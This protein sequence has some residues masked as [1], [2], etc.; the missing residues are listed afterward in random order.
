M[1]NSIKA[2]ES[3]E[4]QYESHTQ[5]QK[6]NYECTQTNMKQCKSLFEGTR[7]AHK[8]VHSFWHTSKAIEA[9]TTAFQARRSFAAGAP[10]ACAAAA[11]PT[12]WT[13]RSFGCSSR[14]CLYN[15]ALF[16]KFPT[17]LHWASFC[18]FPSPPRAAPTARPSGLLALGHWCIF[19][20]LATKSL[21]NSQI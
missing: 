20:G 3:I 4:S 12:G 11:T 7:S 15:W 5:M 10:A 9:A 6:Q 16:C 14:S 17:P 13:G 8:V 19:W 18:K 2:Y 1:W 21:L